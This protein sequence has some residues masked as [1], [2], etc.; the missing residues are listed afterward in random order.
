MQASASPSLIPVPFANSGT[1]NVIPTNASP[2]PGLASLD[3][4][5]PPLTMTPIAAGGIPPAGADFNGILNLLS[6]ANRWAQAGGG[7]TYSST[8]S[9]AIGG[10]P[11]GAVLLNASMTG[12]WLNGVDNNTSNPDAGGANWTAVLTNVASTT[13]A[14]I[15][16]IATTAQAQALS[17]DAA[18]LTPKKLD[19]ALKGSNQ[20]LLYPAG[21]QKLPGGLIIVWG[22]FTFSGASSTTATF[23]LAFPNQCFAVWPVNPANGIAV[24]TTTITKTNVT[25]SYG[26]SLTA[27]AAY[28]AIGW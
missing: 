8:F 20:S 1:K 5:F 25:F 18:A 12:F 10:Y 7:Y 16:A 28:F 4:G 6:A 14:G 27:Q 21:F 9:T 3:T 23:P 17:N 11:K 13:A 22:G 26:S 24:T 15:I 19:D 2:T